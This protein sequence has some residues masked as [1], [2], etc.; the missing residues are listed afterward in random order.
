MS[1]DSQQPGTNL[2]TVQHSLDQ[3]MLEV[4]RIPLLSREEERELTLRLRD[5]DDKEAA[6]GGGRE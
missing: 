6:Q 4:G 5:E 1:K 2:P 3:Y